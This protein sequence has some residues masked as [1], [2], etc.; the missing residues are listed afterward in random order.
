MNRQ[1]EDDFLRK[2]LITICAV[3]TTT[4]LVCMVFYAA[5]V[6]LLLFAGILFAVFLR[7]VGEWIHRRSR[8]SKKFS[9]CIVLF[10][11]VLLLTVCFH[12][13]IPTI[14][15]QITELS[16]TLPKSFQ[17]TTDE[18]M[19]V[20]WFRLTA[21]YLDQHYLFPS[22]DM[23]IGKT[24]PVITT[25][26]GGVIGFFI[27]MIIGFYVSIN[28]GMYINGF[29]RFIPIYKRKRV[30]DFFSDTEIKLRG[31]LFGQFFDMLSIGIMTTIGLSLLKVPLAFI[32]G[33]MAGVLTFIP[34]FGLIL[35]VIPAVVL[36]FAQNPQLAVYVIILYLGAHFIEAYFLS[37]WIQFHAVSLPP[38]LVIFPQLLIGSLFGFPGLA[39]ATPLTLVALILVKYFYIEDI[40]GD[41]EKVS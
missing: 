27:M 17:K 7:G 13:F 1:T 21:K 14:S 3:M 36:A 22:S 31:W 12:A 18:L 32:L 25:M 10:L 11:L 8:F 35:S 15:L 39:L 38:L 4:G 40:L 23:L 16:D 24:A 2:V 30:G 28:S 6:F 19:K 5:D 9:I 20:E 29:L 33:L 37:P 26:F 41:C 34:N